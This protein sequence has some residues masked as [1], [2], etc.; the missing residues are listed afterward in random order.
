MQTPTAKQCMELGEFCA[1]IEGRITGAKEIETLQE[2]E[3]STILEYWGS[4]I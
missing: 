1:R 4:Q 3:Q 2:D